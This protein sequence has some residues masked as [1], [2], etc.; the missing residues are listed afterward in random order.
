M[1]Q[2]VTDKRIEEI[3]MK[4][5]ITD[6]RLGGIKMML[7]AT[8]NRIEMMEDKLDA[9]V[10]WLSKAVANIDDRTSRVEQ[11]MG[12]AECRIAAP[13]AAKR[14]ETSENSTP[15]GVNNQSPNNPGAEGDKSGLGVAH[16]Q[17]LYTMLPL[18][19]VACHLYNQEWISRRQ[20]SR[21][22]PHHGL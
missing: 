8:D 5:E 18:L 19:L 13:E 21:A 6:K 1:K 12:S 10:R 3:K 9:V 17:I 22:M 4:Q 11:R 16:Q 7:E 20:I 2:E 15:A 14:E